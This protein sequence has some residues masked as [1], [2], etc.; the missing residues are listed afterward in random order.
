LFSNGLPYFFPFREKL[1]N[2]NDFIGSIL[3]SRRGSGSL[4]GDHLAARGAHQPLKPLLPVISEVEN[5]ESGNFGFK[6]RKIS[7]MGLNMTEA[8]NSEMF[9]S[10]VID[11]SK[12]HQV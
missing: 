3:G 2:E 8:Q 5:D 11:Q 4:D 9:L 7:N 12:F 1:A 6:D 10:N